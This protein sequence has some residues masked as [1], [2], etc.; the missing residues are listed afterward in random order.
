MSA[1]PVTFTYS[2]V[3]NLTTAEGIMSVATAFELE[4][5]TGVNSIY[6]V[7]RDQLREL[8]ALAEM[9]IDAG[10]K[11]TYINNTSIRIHAPVECVQT[12][13]AAKVVEATKKIIEFCQVKFT[14]FTIHYNGGLAG[15]S[16]A[17]PTPTQP[18]KSRLADLVDMARHFGLGTMVTGPDDA[19]RPHTLLI[20][21]V[22]TDPKQVEGFRAM[23]LSLQE[24]KIE[25]TVDKGGMDD[26]CCYICVPYKQANLLY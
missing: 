1:S 21:K 8:Q 7:S 25:H 15:M 2:R 20:Q 6:V 19:N 22:W 13:E 24:L 18:S 17:K 3:P 10:V 12:K 5:A 16:P 14:N 11:F 9:L 4:L 23:L 26:N